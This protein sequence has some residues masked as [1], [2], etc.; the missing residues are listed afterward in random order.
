MIDLLANLIKNI[1]DFGLEKVFHR[2]YSL[3]RGQV[4]DNTDP[5]HRGRITIKVPSLF[6]D[7]ELATLAEPRDF[8]GAG[9]NKG[10]FYPPDI[11]D[12]VFVEFEMGDPNYPIYSGGWHADGELSEDEFPHVDDAPTT[13]GTMNAYGHVFKFSEEEGKQK[14]YLSTPAG[15]YFILDDTSGEE[16]LY[17]IHTSGAQFQVDA[18]G[19]VKLVCTDGSFVSLDA[20]QGSVMVTSKD[21]SSVVL[22][23]DVTLMPSTGNSLLNLAD[24]SATLTSDGDLIL[25]GNTATINAGSLVVNA[26]GSMLKLGNAQIAIGAGPTELVDQIIQALQAIVS[27]PSLCTTATGPSSPLIP[28]ASVTILQVIAFL[29]AIKGTLG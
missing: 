6:G 19:S 3:Y 12:W 1:T 4:T 13:K 26:L 8:R 5:D 27:A 17:L 25:G 18:A 21:G 22:Q 15:H 20:E 16:A 7:K 11:D 10:D 29:T 24:G 23:Q 14:I 2:Y 28:P 9:P